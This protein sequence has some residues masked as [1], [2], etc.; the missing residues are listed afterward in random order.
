MLWTGSGSSKG[1]GWEEHS[2]QTGEGGVGQGPHHPGPSHSPYLRASDQ[3]DTVFD[4]GSTGRRKTCS[5]AETRFLS[6]VSSLQNLG[7]LDQMI[8]KVTQHIAFNSFHPSFW[9]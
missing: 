5:L 7:E 2:E 9:L 8:F 6:L 4:V 3:T 1:V